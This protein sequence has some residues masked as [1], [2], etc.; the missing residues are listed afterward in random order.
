MLRSYWHS[1]A[2]VALR[3]TIKNHEFPNSVIC[4]LIEQFIS[5]INVVLVGEKVHNFTKFRVRVEI[6][7]FLNLWH[8][9]FL[10]VPVS[11]ECNL[12]KTT[13]T[14]SPEI[15]AIHVQNVSPRN[16]SENRIRI[17]NEEARESSS[18]LN[19]SSYFWDYLRK[20]ILIINKQKNQCHWKSINWL[21]SY[22]FI[23]SIDLDIFIN[24]QFIYQ[25]I[26]IRQR[27]QS[28]KLD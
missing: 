1:F 2:S 19:E 9:F 16:L 5:L 28:L 13:I 20:V 17:E 23:S 12:L 10:F 14:E 24:F 7:D 21:G 25:S 8:F 27:N 22:Q 4:G 3:N 15:R 6:C 18:N 26:C 11:C